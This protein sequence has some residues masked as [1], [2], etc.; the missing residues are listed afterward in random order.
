MRNYSISSAQCPK[1]WPELVGLLVDEAAKLIDA[2]MPNLHIEFI[3]PPWAITQDF[4][5]SRVRI[6]VDR[7]NRV[8]M[9][10]SIG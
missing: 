10:P 7:F 5:S 6:L 4:C 9:P 8:G 1:T 2:E 3:H